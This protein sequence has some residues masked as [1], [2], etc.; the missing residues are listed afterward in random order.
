MGEK[1]VSLV[2]KKKGHLVVL[3]VPAALVAF[4]P[5]MDRI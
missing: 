1:S 5:Q 2:L 4:S 3:L